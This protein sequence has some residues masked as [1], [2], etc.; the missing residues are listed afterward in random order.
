MRGAGPCG[1]GLRAVAAVIFAAAAVARAEPAPGEP[2]SASALPLSARMRLEWLTAAGTTVPREGAVNPDNAVLRLPQAAASTE[3]RPDLALEAGRDLQGHVRPRLLL[4]VQKPRVAGAWQPESSDAKVEWIDLYASWQADERAAFA[5]GLQNY[6]WGPADLVSPS[7]RIF[8]VTGFFRD[9]L[10]VV[11]GKHLARVNLSAGR[12]WSAVLL[13]E[14]RENGEA[15]FVAGARFE[16]KA[17]A[18]LE[19][20]DPGGRGY[21]AVTGGAGRDS[22][23]FFGGYAAL[24]IGDGF[25]VYGDSVTQVGSRAWY[26]VD[27]GAG[28]ARFEHALADAGLRTLAL[29]GVRYTFEGGTDLRLEYLFDEAGWDVARLRLARRAASA[30]PPPGAVEAWLDPGFEIVGRQHAY[31]SLTIPDLPPRKRTSI[32]L[33][34][35]QAIEDGSGA[36]FTTASYAATDA[37]VLFASATG[38]YGSDHGALSRLARATALAGATVSW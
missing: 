1:V 15:P 33:R 24:S 30:P 37:V 36:V 38:A 34:W 32:A 31:A 12:A 28:G 4:Q 35:L 10:Y 8:H 9:P 18:K 21:A 5:Y 7:N 25:S 22:R 23:G 27:D 29:G 13:A 14:V 19:W 26:P 16:P 6:Q 17:Q 2:A 20:S 3:L 11:R